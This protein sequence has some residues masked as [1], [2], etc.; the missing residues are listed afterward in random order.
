M[1]LCVHFFG[2]LSFWRNESFFPGPNY[3]ASDMYCPTELFI[4]QS[5]I[6]NKYMESPRSA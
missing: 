4:C 6:L 1:P 3:Y 5:E 2:S